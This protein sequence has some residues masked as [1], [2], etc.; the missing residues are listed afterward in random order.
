MCSLKLVEFL[1][2]HN[3]SFPMKFSSACA[4]L[5]Y[6]DYMAENIPDANNASH[7]DQKAGHVRLCREPD[8]GV[9]AEVDLKTEEQ[10]L[11][12]VS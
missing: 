11:Y 12:L 6:D 7:D 3:H 8:W 5:S 4:P 9:E 2:S 1:T 10:S